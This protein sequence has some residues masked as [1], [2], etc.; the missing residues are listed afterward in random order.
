MVP[1]VAR[2]QEARQSRV[3]VSNKR[4]GA[5]DC[6]RR[7]S[8]LVEMVGRDRRGTPHMVTE[9]DASMV[10]DEMKE[11]GLA[12]PTI[13]TQFVMVKGFFQRLV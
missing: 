8:L 11:A 3:R 2:R 13:R 9:R 7:S 1:A 6:G 5:D 12:A 10:V 4:G